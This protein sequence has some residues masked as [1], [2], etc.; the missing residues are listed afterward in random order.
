MRSSRVGIWLTWCTLTIVRAH[1]DVQA[2]RQLSRELQ[3]VGY[4]QLVDGDGH[5]LVDEAHAHFEAAADRLD[6]PVLQPLRLVPVLGRQ[7]DSTAS[8]S[9]AAAGALDAGIEALDRLDVV[10]EDRLPTG[11]ARPA[12]MRELSAIAGDLARELRALDLGPDDGI[13]DRLAIAHDEFEGDVDQ[14]ALSS[15]RTEAA[16]AG[17]ADVFE[18]PG[19]WLLLAANNAEMQNGS[20]MFLSYSVMNVAEGDISMD[21]VVWTEFL[22]PSH[23]VELDPDQAAAWPWMDPNA[24]FRHLGTSPRFDATAETAA[25]LFAASG[26]G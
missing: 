15:E 25:A 19:R 12:A 5:E 26:G 24:D 10:L 7:L 18:G 13:L 17:L 16:A 20:G 4:V 8:L 3:H 9:G 23:R 6:Q 2:G 22:R 21:E 11:A 14:L 1:E